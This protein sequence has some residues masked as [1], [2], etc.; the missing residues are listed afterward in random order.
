MQIELMDA[1]LA[2]P[3]L[4]PAIKAIIFKRDFIL[5]A[6]H[7]RAGL[8]EAWLTKVE[9]KPSIPPVHCYY[10]HTSRGNPIV[11]D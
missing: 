1:A 6:I 8:Q 7:S 2:T 4:A 11:K 9:G 10:I 3:A 5:T